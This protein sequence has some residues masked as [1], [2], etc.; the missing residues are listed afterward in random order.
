MT[1]LCQHCRT[2]V[3][4]GAAYCPQCGAPQLRVPGPDAREGEQEASAGEVLPR[5]TGEIVWPAAIK[6]AAIY[7]VPAG[8]LLSFLAVPLFDMLWVV[9]G[10]IWTLRQ[11]RRQAPRA[12]VLTPE[13]GGRIGLVLGLFAAVVSTGADG[14]SF[15]VERYGLHRGALIDSRLES[16]V[17]AGINRIHASNPDAAAQLPGLI[18]FCLSPEGRGSLLLFSAAVTVLSV[19]LFAWLT[20]RYSVRFSLRPARPKSQA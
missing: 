9:A 5:H 6:A 7:A 19:L 4:E 16:G 15:L 14:A 1:T 10:V 17:Q 20:G 11:Y 8:L 13:L 2:A 18:Q 12:P 3:P